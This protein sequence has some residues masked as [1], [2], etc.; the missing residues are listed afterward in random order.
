MNDDNW[1][2][3][4][5]VKVGICKNC[6]VGSQGLDRG[7]EPLMATDVCIDCYYETKRSEEKVIDTK[8]D[9]QLQELDYICKFYEHRRD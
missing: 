8:T 7:N 1:P 9:G 4:K 2:M 3:P 6:F 5:Y